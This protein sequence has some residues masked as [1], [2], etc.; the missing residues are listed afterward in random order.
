MKIEMGVHGTSAVAEYVG[1]GRLVNIDGV[2]WSDV[3]GLRKGWGTLFRGAAQSFNW[4]H[5]AVPTPVA[6]AA[7]PTASA[8]LMSLQSIRI[9]FQTFGTSRVSRV[10]VWAGG[11]RILTKD[12]LDLFGDF[13]S[14][15]I[16]NQNVFAIQKRLEPGLTIGISVCVVFGATES[17]I[18]FQGASASFTM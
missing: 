4:F 9:N 16:Q 13:R 7:S 14:L 3:A 5:L 17:N 12:G 6:Y 10:H 2:H 18:L 15:S 11:Q 1:P 8:Q